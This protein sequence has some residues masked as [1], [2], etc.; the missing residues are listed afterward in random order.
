M[1]LFAIDLRNWLFTPP[2]HTPP[3]KAKPWRDNLRG[4]FAYVKQSGEPN[5]KQ[6]KNPINGGVLNCRLKKADIRGGATLHVRRWGGQVLGRGIKAWVH[7]PHKKMWQ[8]RLSNHSA[9]PTQQHEPSKN[10]MQKKTQQPR[11]HMIA[12]TND[13]NNNKKSKGPKTRAS[14]P[15]KY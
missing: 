2:W 8:W 7:E 11:K 9:P 13:T 15:C 6:D 4:K 14:V 5:T 12:D 3:L 1:C 10:A